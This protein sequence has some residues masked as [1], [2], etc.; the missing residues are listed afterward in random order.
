MTDYSIVDVL[1]HRPPMV[2]LDSLVEF[3]RQSAICEV[4]IQTSSPFYQ[5]VIKGVPAYIGIEYM[6]QTI[7]AYAGANALNDGEQ[8]KP[9]FLLGSRKYKIFESNFNVQTRYEI[10]VEEVYKED[11]GLSVFDCAIYEGNNL[12]VVAKLNVFQPDDPLSFIKD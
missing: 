6:A 5:D 9:G 12:V 2:L 7:A 11:S 1:A 3:D 4:T 10:K 8:V